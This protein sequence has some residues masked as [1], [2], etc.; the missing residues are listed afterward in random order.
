MSWEVNLNRIPKNLIAILKGLNNQ[1]RI[2]LLEKIL[3]DNN[4]S[5]SK[6]QK[7]T[8][9][10]NGYIL[11]HIHTLELAG[12][13]QNY[14][15]KSTTSREYS[16]YSV[17]PLGGIIFSCIKKVNSEIYGISKIAEKELLLILKAIS[18]PF[19]FALL[20]S[21]IEKSKL[22]FTEILSLTKEENT[23]IANHLHK[24]EL[25]QLIQ[26]FYQ[27]RDAKSDYSF[28]E[29]T[30]LGEKIIN[31]IIENY[32]NYYKQKLDN[33]NKEQVESELMHL[34]IMPP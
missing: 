30:N 27:K 12:I 23:I 15:K 19:R 18:N 20:E 10:P 13:I 32:N 11:N 24:L 1:F 26:N 25:A 34:L 2:Q 14:V 22:S 6:I 16:F 21:I 17:T 31:S 5:L 8:Q 3:E 7:F 4:I 33:K 28:Y 9:K 29:K